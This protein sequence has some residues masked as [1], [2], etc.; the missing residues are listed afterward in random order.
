MQGWAAGGREQ[1]SDDTGIEASQAKKTQR[2]WAG[3]AA[4]H[5]CQGADLS[6]PSAL[7]TQ[8]HWQAPGH[9]QPWLSVWRHSH[10]LQC[11][12]CTAAFMV[13]PKLLW[14]GQ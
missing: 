1:G 8:M 6:C 2:R 9:F 10:R 14:H 11:L 13:M 4:K 7:A 12:H 3:G 5:H